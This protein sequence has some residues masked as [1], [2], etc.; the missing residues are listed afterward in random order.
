[1]GI[2]AKKV[3]DNFCSKKRSEAIRCSFRVDGDECNNPRVFAQIR[4][5]ISKIDRYLPVFSYPG[6]DWASADCKT[7]SSHL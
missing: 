4:L 6:I 5:L 3:T 2:F 1:M 7:Q